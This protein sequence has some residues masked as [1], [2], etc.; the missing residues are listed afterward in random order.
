MYVRH[1]DA[2]AIGA[3]LAGAVRQLS[4]L[5]CCTHVRWPQHDATQAHNDM[6]RCNRQAN[7]ILYMTVDVLLVRPCFQLPAGLPP[8][9]LSR[10]RSTPG[11]RRPSGPPRGSL[12]PSLPHRRGLPAPAQLP[13]KDSTRVCGIWRHCA[14][15]K[16]AV[17]G[18]GDCD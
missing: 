14:Y 15:C 4:V 2:N 11:A 10:L 7:I 12:Q 16:A 5:L 18:A 13:G 17:Y 1:A 6:Q 9:T 8:G 3:Y